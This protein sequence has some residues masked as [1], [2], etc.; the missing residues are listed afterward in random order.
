MLNFMHPVIIASIEDH[1]GKLEKSSY[2]HTHTWETTY[3]SRYK[4]LRR[5]RGPRRPDKHSIPAKRT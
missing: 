1:I 5:H 4:E 3:I 2:R